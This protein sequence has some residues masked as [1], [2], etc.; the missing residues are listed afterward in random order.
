MYNLR[1][2]WFSKSRQR[3]FIIII[4]LGSQIWWIWYYYELKSQKT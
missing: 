1:S 4:K 3:R 2:S